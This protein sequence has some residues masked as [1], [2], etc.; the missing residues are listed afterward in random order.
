MPNYLIALL[1]AGIFLTSCQQPK[2]R[3]HQ[4]AI[5][6]MMEKYGDDP[7]AG[8]PGPAARPPSDDIVKSG[9]L[10]E[11]ETVLVTG[12]NNSNGI[13]DPQERENGLSAY[14]D[15]LKLN[16][17]GSCEYTIG[18]LEANFEVVEKDGHQSLEIIAPD[19]SRL[20]KGRIISLKP[21]ELQLMKFS[22]GRDIIV[23]KRP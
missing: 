15:Y 12:D 22:G 1:I 6:D 23:Y 14:K 7:K 18:K 13:L 4:A 19:G 21:N 2:A 17:D 8:Q 16:P 5:N 10:G 9:L 3:Q 11:W 20:K